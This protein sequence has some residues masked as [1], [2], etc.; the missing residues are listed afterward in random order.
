MTE[1]HTRAA[2]TDDGRRIGVQLADQDHQ[3]LTLVLSRQAG[4]ASEGG[5]P[6]AVR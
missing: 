6:D 5:R 1:L 3:A 2:L 4:H